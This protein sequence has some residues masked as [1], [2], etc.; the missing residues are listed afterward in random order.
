MFVGSQIKSGREFQ[1][2]GPATE[3]AASA[4]FFFT[5]FTEAAK[6]HSNDDGISRHRLV[7]FNA[8]YLT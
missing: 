3:N 6:V 4:S 8:Y 2:I 7:P 1:A 5:E